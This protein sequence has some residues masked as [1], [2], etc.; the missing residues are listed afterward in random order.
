MAKNFTLKI[1]GM[2]AVG[3]VCV[4]LGTLRVPG[5]AGTFHVAREF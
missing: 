3:N 2:K 1:S 4:I 5:S